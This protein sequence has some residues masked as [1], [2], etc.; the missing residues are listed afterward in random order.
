MTICKQLPGLGYEGIRSFCRFPLSFDIN[1]F[2]GDVS[3]IGVALDTGTTNRCGARYGPQAI[4]EGSMIYSL[5]F[6]E[7]G[8]LFDVDVRKTILKD[9]RVVDCGDIPT[10]PTLLKETFKMI[11]DSVQVIRSRGGITVVLGGDHSVSFPVVRGLSDTPCHV[12]Q[13]DAHLDLMDDYL[14]MKYT[15]GNPM[16][17]ILEMEHVSGLTQIGIRG[18]LN[19]E[20]WTTGQ[21]ESKTTIITADEVHDRGVEWAA[22]KIPETENLYISIDIDVLDPKEA[23]GTGTPEFGG[24]YYRQLVRLLRMTLGKGK[25]VGLDL[26]EVNPLFDPTG[27]TGQVAARLI[28]D[29]LGAATIDSSNK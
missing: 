4:R 21:N 13:F 1:K 8:E 18:L 7:S 11:T 12:V 28:L 15:H 27:R 24:L 2:D 19:G 29:T 3:V 22:A 16:K 10:P 14:G 17:R 9:L 23:P 5:G 25:L 6:A 26:V 20:D